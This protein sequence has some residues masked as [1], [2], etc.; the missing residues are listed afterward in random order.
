M[1]G[2][3][4]P[5]TAASARGASNKRGRSYTVNSAEPA[6]APFVPNFGFEHVWEP[7]YSATAAQPP[8]L[9]RYAY[10]VPEGGVVGDQRTIKDA[11]HA[12]LADLAPDELNYLSVCGELISGAGSASRCVMHAAL[13]GHQGSG[14]TGLGA[15]SAGSIV[16]F[17]LTNP[18]GVSCDMLADQVTE[19]AGR[20]QSK[21]RPRRRRVIEASSARAGRETPL[22]ALSVVD[23]VRVGRQVFDL[24]S[25]GTDREPRSFA[26]QRHSGDRDAGRRPGYRLLRPT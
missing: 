3:R 18:N 12:V 19:G 20:L 14:P 13:A 2:R 5:S 1:E 17:V 26:W 8:V 15:D 24:G 7:Y 16:V 9:L 6:T 10:I 21:W 11:A 22:S 23:A 4:T 25:S